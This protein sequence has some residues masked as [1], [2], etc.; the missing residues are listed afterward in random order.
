MQEAREAVSG[1]DRHR[2]DWEDQPELL[3][4]PRIGHENGLPSKPGGPSAEQDDGHK[5]AQ[6]AQ[7]VRH[8]PQRARPA[9]DRRNFPVS[10]VGKG[11]MLAGRRAAPYTS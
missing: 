10:L 5:E 11:A 8:R 6:G 3:I 9:R 1:V 7:E 2:S 4:G